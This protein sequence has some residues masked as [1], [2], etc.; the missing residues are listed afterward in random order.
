MKN[1]TKDFRY[2]NYQCNGQER[3]N[4]REGL[5]E[6]KSNYKERLYITIKLLTVSVFAK[7]DQNV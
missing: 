5:N 4:V 7:S 1:E 6:L 3:R 2:F